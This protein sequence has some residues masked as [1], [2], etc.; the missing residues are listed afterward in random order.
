MKKHNP[1]KQ[2]FGKGQRGGAGPYTSNDV[3]LYD[4]GKTDAAGNPI[5]KKRSILD[6]V[7][8]TSGMGLSRTV[9]KPPAKRYDPL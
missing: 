3:E 8:S 2:A 4:Y 9:S 5:V 1:G 7:E 6:D